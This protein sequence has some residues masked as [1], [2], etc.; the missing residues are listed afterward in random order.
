MSFAALALWLGGALS[1]TS[2]ANEPWRYR[3]EFQA[4]TQLLRVQVC[5][6]SA[7]V[8][9]VL[10]AL[11]RPALEHLQ[12]GSDWQLDER[13]WQIRHTG[14]ACGGYAVDLG[15]LADRRSSGHGYRVGAD[16]LTWP[17]AWLWWPASRSVEA[18][19]EF[20]L[21]DGWQISTPWPQPD[22]LR[23]EFRLGGW[24][25]DWPG[26]VALGHFDRRLLEGSAEG[27]RLAMLG[28]IERGRR[29]ELARWVTHLAELLEPVGG[30]PLPQAQVLIVPMNRGN[31]P[32]PWGQVHRA[33]FGGVHFFVNPQHSLQDFVD[34]WTGAHE[35]SHLLHPYLGRRGRWLSEGLAS[36]YQNVLRARSGDLSEF[37]AWE[38]L[39]AGFGR[40]RRDASGG[41]AL[42]EVARQMQQRRA[43]MRVYWSGAA[44]WL[45]RDVEL[46]LQ[47][48]TA[49]GLD[50]LL[51]RFAMTRLPANRTWSPQEFAA[52]LDRLAGVSVFVPALAPA[53]SEL[54]FPN[55]AP[56]LQRLG[57]IS[58]RSGEL[59]RLDDE[60]ELTA[61]RQAIMA[62]S[63]RPATG[64]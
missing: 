37:E 7:T 30:L 42:L 55:V 62:S 45:Q 47:L 63:G 36:Y 41:T 26:L 27:V 38:R 15:R 20:E 34:D 12:I 1:L 44:W 18:V 33:G 24:P 53:E 40:G 35:F 32:V 14:G 2:T 43:F 13:R 16:L 5:T 19:I 21:P 51:R 29:D 6:P 31:G 46:R 39:L 56:L 4:D 10:R 52:E 60:A 25:R 8:P 9:L 49:N 28:N 17:D 3:A 48:G 64:S 58:D 50:A 23:S 61:L 57:L 59:R 11:D 22:P 54:Q